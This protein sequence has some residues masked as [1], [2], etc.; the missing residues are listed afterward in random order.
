[1]T[2]VLLQAAGT[3]VAITLIINEELQICYPIKVHL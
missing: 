2:D 1:M 3:H